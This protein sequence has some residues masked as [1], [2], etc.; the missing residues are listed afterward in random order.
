MDHLASAPKLFQPVQVG[1]ITLGHRVVFAPLTRL[2]ADRRGAHS[3]MGM[4]YYAQRASFP[5]TLII[6]EATYVASFAQGRSLHAPGVYTEDQIA[7]WKRG[8]FI[9][10]QLWGVGRA[11]RSPMLA[12]LREQDPNFAYV[13]A[14]DVPLSGR[15]EVPRP[16]TVAG[17]PSSKSDGGTLL[18]TKAEIKGYIAAF[19]QAARNAVERA[20]FDGVEIHAAHG[21]LL[22]QF[23][24]E[25]ANRRTDE[26]GGSIENRCRFALEVVDAVSD[27]IGEHRSAVRISPWS[28]FQDMKWDDPVPT[29]TYLVS[30]LAADH[31]RLAYIHVVEPGISGAA[32]CSLQGGESNEFIRKIW[33]PRPLISAGGYTR[34]KA[35]RVAEETGQLIAFGR[36]FPA[37]LQPD[38]PLRLLENIPLTPWDREVFYTPEDPSGYIDYPFSG[39]GDY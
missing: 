19:A 37:T 9:H 5:G 15:D 10:M 31:P 29:F 28:D 26:Y 14:S 12:E 24:H 39:L 35:L 25:G 20:G 6:S 17:K 27:A 16:L 38:L 4:E 22:E 32:D 33:L 1:N 36:P 30:R 7:A 21:Y 34:D 8:S 18:T 11:A 23:I 3:D 2:R 13:S